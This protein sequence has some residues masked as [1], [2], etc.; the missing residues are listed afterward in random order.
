MPKKMYIRTK[1]I[2][3]KG[4]KFKYAYL[5]RSKRRK[6][7]IKQKTIK[8]LGKV[9][10]PTPLNL[11]FNSF[12]G[13]DLYTFMKNTTKKEISLK[14]IQFELINHG[15]KLAK[16]NVYINK[17]VKIDLNKQKIEN[18]KLNKAVLEINEGFLC[19][20]TFISL[21]N[22][23]FPNLNEKECGKYLAKTL[24]NVGIKLNNELFIF[25]FKKFYKETIPSIE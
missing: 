17:E 5:V 2:K 22:F 1:T 7:K 14:L 21:L 16:N 23:K 20:F 19:D 3:Y 15:F 11:D 12:L 9:Y 8:Y 25:L 24:L 4:S 18:N 6:A 10:E 13:Q